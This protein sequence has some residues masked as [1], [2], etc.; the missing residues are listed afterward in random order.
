LRKTAEEY[1]RLAADLEN[2]SVAIQQHQQVLPD[3]KV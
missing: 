2:A 3:N 1:D